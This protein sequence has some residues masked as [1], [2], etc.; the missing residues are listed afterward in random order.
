[1]PRRCCSPSP[2]PPA[3]P[4]DNGEPVRNTGRNTKR[5]QRDQ[6]NPQKKKSKK[7]K[8]KSK[9]SKKQIREYHTCVSWCLSYWYVIPSH[10]G[11]VTKRQDLPK[12]N[13]KY[14]TR[15]IEARSRRGKSSNKIVKIVRA[16]PQRGKG[17]QTF[18]NIVGARPRGGKAWPNIREHRSGEVTERQDWR[19]ADTQKRPPS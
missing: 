9:K 13:R 19:G 16:R 18:V 10:M 4:R 17:R 6:R 12:K 3:L 11:E 5:D 8:K 7:S 1:M 15:Y 14:H 2:N